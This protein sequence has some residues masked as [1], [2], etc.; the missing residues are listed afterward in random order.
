MAAGGFRPADTIQLA[1]APADQDIVGV[2]VTTSG[3]DTAEAPGMVEQVVQRLGTL[4]ADWSMDG[5]FA[6]Q[7]VIEQVAAAGVRVGAPVA[8]PTVAE[9]DPL[10]PVPTDSPVLAAWRVR[11]GLEDSTRRYRLRAATIACVTATAR[12]LHGLTQ[13]RVRCVALWVAL[14]HHRTLLVT[15]PPPVTPAP[16]RAACACSA[17]AACWPARVPGSRVG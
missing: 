15:A 2:A 11:M 3:S 1:A 8:T 14:A 12:T 17:I 7:Q 4:P 6:S 16:A 5:G 9:R 13:R 10:H